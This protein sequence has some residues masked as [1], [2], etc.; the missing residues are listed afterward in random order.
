MHKTYVLLVLL[1]LLGC[2]AEQPVARTEDQH[3]GTAVAPVTSTQFPFASG[4]SITLNGQ[5]RPNLE[6]QEATRRT[7]ANRGTHAVRFSPDD[8][9]VLQFVSQKQVRIKIRIVVTDTD[10]HILNDA[11]H[12]VQIWRGI[13]ADLRI[14]PDATYVI[15]PGQQRTICFRMRVIELTPSGPSTFYVAFT[16]FKVSPPEDRDDRNNDDPRV[17]REF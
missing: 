1:G 10:N 3:R 14:M 7:L 2:A 15:P 17:M 8:F 6:P 9:F 12:E 5:P 16:D 13:P 11:I 4:A